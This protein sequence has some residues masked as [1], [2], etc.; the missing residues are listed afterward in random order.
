V[1]ILFSQ[2]TIERPDMRAFLNFSRRVIAGFTAIAVALPPVGG[3][4]NPQGGQVTAGAAS[5]QGQGSSR[6]TVN[7]SS[8][9]AIINW[10]TF[11][12]APNEITHFVQPGA[13]SVVLNRVTGGLG[14][15][16]INGVIKANGGVYI[17]NPDG[18]LFGP[19]A[20][21]NVGSFLGTTHNIADNDFMTGKNNFA[22]PGNPSASIVNQGSVTAASG[23]FAALVAPGVRNDGIITVP[24][25]KI[26]LASGNGFT[27]D[28]YGDSLIKL[29][30]GDAIANDVRDVATGQTLATLV[31]NTGK[32]KAKGGTV[33]LTAVAAKQVLDSVINGS[34]VI[35]ANTV[36]TKNGLVVFG[37]AT[38]DALP[39]NAPVQTVKVS[40]KV[41]A[42]GKKTGTT[43]GK[44]QITGQNIQI[45]GAHLN[46]SGKAGGGII[47][48]GGDFSGDNPAALAVTQ[49]GQS[50]E[51]VPTPN[52]TTVSVDA[53]ST[54]NASAVS[55]GNGGKVV[56][57]SNLETAFAGST[58]ATGGTAGGNGGF[59]ETSGAA[60]NIDGSFVSTA[61]PKGQ[62]GHWL[63]D[64]FDFTIDASAASSIKTGLVSGDVS[65][66]TLPDGNP[67]NGD[68]NVKAAITW[69]TNS[70]LLLDAYH[71]VT[72][73]A[74]INGASLAIVTNDKG[75]GGLFTVNAPVT[76][77]SGYSFNGAD[78]Q[79]VTTAQQL[80]AISSGNYALGN[81]ITLT[82]SFTPLGPPA[83]FGNLEGLGHTISGLSIVGTAPDTTAGTGTSAGLF[84]AL[85]GTIENLTVSGANITG[86][87][88][89]A[90]VL[91][92][93]S[94]GTIYNVAVSGAITVT[95]QPTITF[96]AAIGGL[97]G[98][99][100]GQIISS[101]ASVAL[102][103][104]NTLPNGTSTDNGGLAGDN[105][106]AIRNSYATGSVTGNFTDPSG[107]EG[108]SLGG[109]IGENSSGTVTNSYSTGNV[110]AYVSGATNYGV[111]GWLGSFIGYNFNPHNATVSGYATGTVQA[112][113]CP[114]CSTGGLVGRGSAIAA[115][116]DTITTLT[117]QAQA[118]AALVAQA[119]QPATAVTTPTNPTTTETG[120]PATSAVNSTSVTS[121]LPSTTMT[122]LASVTSGR[123]AA[124]SGS[125]LSPLATN[126]NGMPQPPAATQNS[127]YNT[128]TSA[129][130]SD[131]G[132]V[133]STTQTVTT[134]EGQYA[135]AV[136]TSL[137]EVAIYSI[138]G[139]VEVGD[140]IS[141]IIYAVSSNDS[142]Y[143][144][145]QKLEAAAILTYVE[146]NYRSIS[147][148]TLNNLKQFLDKVA[149]GDPTATAQ[150][151]TGFLVN[152]VGVGI[153]ADAV[154][155]AQT[156][157]GGAAIRLLKPIVSPIN[158][159]KDVLDQL[160]ERQWTIEAIIDTIDNPYTVR[161]STNK[162]TGNTATVFY[163]KDGSYVIVDDGTG[164]IVQISDRGDPNW[165]PDPRIINPYRP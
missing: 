50:F 117:A 5:I 133:T 10:Q 72:V 152:I 75:T 110:T 14:A 9:R 138:K 107:V 91:A 40:G 159:E 36:G 142:A 1:A 67:G 81:D 30:P 70:T 18:I 12:I 144:K 86:S 146:N 127:S 54:I 44:I 108:G 114:S 155:A 90:G 98:A 153:A 26:A 102:T 27:L 154:R 125:T 111:F 121:T 41:T 88:N 6:V 106:G 82:G 145:E 140:K 89:A 16:D 123:S 64:P 93:I 38:A 137:I 4:A 78:Y 60:L 126:N 161:V 51:M 46:A 56:V 2:C 34:G 92:G 101:N 20:R 94:Y 11:N 118:T 47:L 129:I 25:G 69:S 55:S 109:L 31:Q 128:I 3:R 52:A 33:T 164:D 42:A 135:Q 162:F 87:S 71:S 143:I 120:F 61:A 29:Q 147:A 105:T 96:E 97:V 28:F 17:V 113:N 21:I 43:G 141:H 68:I 15:S 132:E 79:L 13:S 134:A 148:N 99:N 35:E 59:V 65:I 58:L 136:M 131:M 103:Y 24:L 63:L 112:V 45:S 95:V 7:Q 37:A 8:S 130:V 74:P 157:S 19:S 83:F 151:S 124:S 53:A 62:P 32:L 119:S 100:S 57:W 85:G 39:T 104:N 48:V 76:L 158:I 115:T 122:S 84:V 165:I 150:L 23:G 73:N 49:Y 66:A 77:S 139:L 22:I 149:S 156:A 80:Q 163:E 116:P 160:V